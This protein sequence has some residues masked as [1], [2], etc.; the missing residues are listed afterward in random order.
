MNPMHGEVFFSGTIV[1]KTWHRRMSGHGPN[2]LPF[3]R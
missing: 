2:H 3:S 1:I